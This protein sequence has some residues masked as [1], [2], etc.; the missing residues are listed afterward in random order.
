LIVIK[1]LTLAAGLLL[2]LGA[3]ANTPWDLNSDR[4][5][6]V[7]GA[8][9]GWVLT[10]EL[11]SDAASLIAQDFVLR[12]F[13]RDRE[14]VVR[15]KSVRCHATTCVV[16]APRLHRAGRVIYAMRAEVDLLDGRVILEG[17]GP[18]STQEET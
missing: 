11:G 8:G 14:I 12:G 4:R 13:A 7:S 10:G 9:G 2:G 3:N 1:C 18:R 17:I 5:T 6:A 15:G 16:D